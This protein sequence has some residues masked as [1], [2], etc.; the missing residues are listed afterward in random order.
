MMGRILYLEFGWSN[1]KLD[2][3]RITAD[4]RNFLTTKLDVDNNPTIALLDL[5]VVEKYPKN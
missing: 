5:E 2:S 4:T 3:K 1:P